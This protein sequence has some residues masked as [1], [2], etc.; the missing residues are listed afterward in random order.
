MAY[1][2]LVII[3]AYLFFG[4]ASFCDKLVLAGKP[5]PKAYTFYVGIFSIFVIFFIPFIG[6]KIP[7]VEG[8]G[9]IAI[10]AIV[11]ILGLY[12][13]FTA[14]ERFEVSK[15]IATIGA[16]QPIFI[17]ILSWLF[18]GPQL[19]PFVDLVAFALLFLGSVVCINLFRLPCTVRKWR[20]F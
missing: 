8:F 20:G 15:V 12:M 4:L 9:W 18:W 10:D 13:M 17:F 16:I 3:L 11:H 1:W 19:I 7:G 6:F 14:L 2:L 5:K